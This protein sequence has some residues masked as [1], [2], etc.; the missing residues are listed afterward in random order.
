MFTVSY[1]RLPQLMKIVVSTQ[2]MQFANGCSPSSCGTPPTV[3]FACMEPIP[4][5]R[6]RFSATRMALHR[7]VRC[8]ACPLDTVAGLCVDP[9]NHVRPLCSASCFSG[10][11]P[12][13]VIPGLMAC[14]QPPTPSGRI[15]CSLE[16]PFSPQL[17]LPLMLPMMRTSF[18]LLAGFAEISFLPVHKHL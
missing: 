14:F 15:P 16:G 10:H 9:L 4:E 11:E 7:V 12:R 8:S 6:A 5:D 1:G 2:L 17:V 13:C 18:A 3:P